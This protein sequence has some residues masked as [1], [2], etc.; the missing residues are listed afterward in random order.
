M[1]HLDRRLQWRRDQR[2]V[3]RSCSINYAERYQRPIRELL[4]VPNLSAFLRGL[5]GP[6]K[7]LCCSCNYH[8]EADHA[9]CDKKISAVERSDRFKECLR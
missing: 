9:R 5:A 6:S 3:S 4:R 7:R 8:T 1:L 2:T